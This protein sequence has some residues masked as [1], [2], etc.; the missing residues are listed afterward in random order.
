MKSKSSNYYRPEH[1]RERRSSPYAGSRWE[2]L[3][4]RWRLILLDLLHPNTVP[5]RHLVSLVRDPG[6]GKKGP[7]VV[8]TVDWRDR[9][10]RLHVVR[11]FIVAQ[12]RPSTVDIFEIGPLN[13]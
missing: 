2:Q 1:L 5:L 8:R 12:E 3:S 6:V 13:V 10:M 11:E 9:L 4:R 7:P